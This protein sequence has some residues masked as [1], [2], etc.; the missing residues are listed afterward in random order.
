MLHW[1]FKTVQAIRSPWI[2]AQCFAYVLLIL[3]MHHLPPLERVP[4][5]MATRPYRYDGSIQHIYSDGSGFVVR[6]A[7]AIQSMYDLF[8]LEPII[9]KYFL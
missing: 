6:M 2:F 1:V 5:T 9:H 3:G 7:E 4:H 8:F